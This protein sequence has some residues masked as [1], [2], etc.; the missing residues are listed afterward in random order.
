[1]K[2]CSKK[3][4]STQAILTFVF[5]SFA[6]AS[7]ALAVVPPPDGG[8][9]N[10]TTAEGT[11]AL[12]NLTSGAANTGI[13]WYS[14]FSVGAANFNTGVGTGTLALNGADSNTAVGVA[15]MLLNTTGTENTAVGAG[16]LLHNDT[17]D[18]NTATGAFAL[19]NHVS[20]VSN[21]ANGWHA[22]LSDTTGQLNTAIGAAALATDNNGFNGSFNTAVGG[23]AL[24][25]NNGGD[26]TAVGAMALQSNSTANDNTAVGLSAL[27]S[28]TTGNSNVALGSF[29]GG[30]QTTGSN[31]IYI[32]AN[33]QGTAGESDVI[34]IG[35][36]QTSAY[37]AGIF[38][39]TVPA[40]NAPV[41]VS[42]GGKLGTMPSSRQFK[43]NISR[44]DSRS[45]VL[46]ALE[47]V[48]FRYKKE[49]DPAGTSQFGLVAEDVQKVSPDLVVQ[50]KSG[51]VY[52]VRYDAV[53]AMLLNEFLKEHQHVQEQDATIARLEKQVE[54]LSA[55][56]QKV[57]T[58]FDLTKTTPQTVLNDQ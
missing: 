19:S 15:A 12:L 5:A 31:N 45:E 26:N 2:I 42:S 1:M 36:T 4:V 6:S 40:T 16:A 58:D 22:L 49:I 10:F 41:Y 21:T 23:S 28:N 33:V 56:L 55:G 14:L 47:P 43:E 17:A 30:N 38:G 25:S 46:F 39:Q 29:A 57:R 8:Y 54:Q 13:G 51:K 44:M 34:Q 35:G 32:G 20:G 27:A 9:A 24:F 7:V 11:N 18:N 53:N 37:V 52:T 3:F 50:D 48:T